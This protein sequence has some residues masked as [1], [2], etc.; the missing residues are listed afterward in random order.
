MGTR[1]FTVCVSC[2]YVCDRSGI[3]ASFLFQLLFPRVHISPLHRL[4][5]HAHL[6]YFTYVNMYPTTRCVRVTSGDLVAEAARGGLL[7]PSHGRGASFS[8]AYGK[9]TS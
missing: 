1:M 2:P 7:T 4:Y 8:P 6:L 5:V 3:C 9:Q